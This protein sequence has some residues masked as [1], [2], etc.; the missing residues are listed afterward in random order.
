MKQCEGDR[1]RNAIAES[2]PTKVGN[3][4][5]DGCKICGTINITTA[6]VVI[7]NFKRKAKVGQNFQAFCGIDVAAET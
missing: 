1:D 3:A 6:R 4:K 5:K 2:T 7:S